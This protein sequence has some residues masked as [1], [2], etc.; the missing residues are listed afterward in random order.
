MSIGLQTPSVL[1]PKTV[2]DL[3]IKAFRTARILG[4]GERLEHGEAV[5]AFELLNGLI[6]QANLDKLFAYTQTDVTVPIQANV[7][8][9]TIGPSTVSPPPMI[10]ATRPVEILA[11]FSRRNGVDFPLFVTHQRSEYDAIR[12]KSVSING[13]INVVYYEASYPAGTLYTYPLI[14]DG[15]TTL[16]ITVSSPVAPFETLDEEV[17]VPPLYAT[18]LQY[19][20][21]ERLCPEYGMTWTDAS[22]K[23]LLDVTAT[24]KGNNIKPFPVARPGLSGLAGASQSYDIYSDTVRPS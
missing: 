21:A 20:L 3:L 11:A 2:R 16:Y 19:A 18:W 5:D 12:V 22:A 14:N 6:D 1:T 23:I 13:W 7:S 15:L 4:V 24:L 10:T 9:Y 8:A 17:D